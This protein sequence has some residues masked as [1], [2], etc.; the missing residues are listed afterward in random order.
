MVKSSSAWARRRE[1]SASPGVATREKMKPRYRDPS[2][3]GTT[4]W[5]LGMEMVTSSMPATARPER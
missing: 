3:S 5:P 1:A 4:G 2:G